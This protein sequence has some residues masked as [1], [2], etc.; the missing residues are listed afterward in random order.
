MSDILA[1][2]KWPSR[3]YSQNVT[4]KDGVFSVELTRNG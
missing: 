2:E 4:A 1:L 3:R